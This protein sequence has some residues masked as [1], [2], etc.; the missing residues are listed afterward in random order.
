MRLLLGLPVLLIVFVAAACDLAPRVTT[1]P[2]RDQWSAMAPM[3][4]QR[5]AQLRNRMTVVGGRVAALTVPPGVQD[6]ALS[7][8]ISDL[9]AQTAT[10]ES[11]VSQFEQTV[12]AIGTEI[13]A[14]L[15]KRDKIRARQLVDLA[16]SRLDQAFA[17]ASAPFTAIEQRLPEAEAGTS[18]YLS[19]VAAE[20]QRTVRVASEGGELVVAMR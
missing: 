18:R 5:V 12:S 20:E 9:Q 3:Q 19:L 4:K 11:A 10:L 14:A 16:G 8:R 2:T 13:D 6:A 17:D 15:G 1:D 7:Q